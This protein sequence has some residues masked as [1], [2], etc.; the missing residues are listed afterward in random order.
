M[1]TLK[2]TWLSCENCDGGNTEKSHV[3]VHTEKGCG[4]RLYGG[5][6]AECPV[7]HEKGVIEAEDGI[8]WVNWEPHND[9]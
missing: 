3:I 5:D 4:F 9:D 6:P 7:C 2:I 8:A 1:K